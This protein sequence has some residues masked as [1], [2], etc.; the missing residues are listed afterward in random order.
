MGATGNYLHPESGRFDNV[1]GDEG[2]T[3]REIEITR[4]QRDLL[5]CADQ[6]DEM[7]IAISESGILQLLLPIVLHTN[8]TTHVGRET[9]YNEIGRLFTLLVDKLTVKQVDALVASCS[10]PESFQFPPLESL[11]DLIFRAESEIAEV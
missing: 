1:H 9:A 2:Y 6:Q 4:I 11:D 10:E 7:T 3:D 8:T 5:N